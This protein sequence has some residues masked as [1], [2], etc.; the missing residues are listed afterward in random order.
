MA[1]FTEVLALEEL[2]PGAS[3]LVRVGGAEV[4]LFNVGGEVYAINDS[5]IHQGASL[6][7]GKV[8]GLV[9]TCRAHGFRYDLRTG[10]IVGAPEIGVASYP[11]KVVDELI[12]VA[13]S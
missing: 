13:V 5:C 11:V 9:V 7:A 3:R 1:E 12:F 6:A 2:P 4:A 8:S 10:C